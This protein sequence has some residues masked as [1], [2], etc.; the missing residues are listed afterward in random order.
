MDWTE[1]LNQFQ[2]QGSIFWVAALSIAGG[3]TLLLISGL[4]LAKR[5]LVKGMVAAWKPGRRRSNSRKPGIK[6]GNHVKLTETGYTVN[7][8]ATAPQEAH[9]AQAQGP[10]MDNLY[11]RLKQAANALEDIH[12]A[13]K[14]QGS[15]TAISGLKTPLKD[16]E[17]VFKSG[18]G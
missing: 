16:V 1:F 5:G 14:N 4:I 8:L 12:L 11:Q 17:Y 15:S 3:G 13:L 7:T 10:G 18:I 2:G 6:P 9:E